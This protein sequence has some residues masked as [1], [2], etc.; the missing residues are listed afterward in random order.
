MTITAEWAA[1]IVSAGTLGVAW[2]Q[3]GKINKQIKLGVEN[4]RQEILRIVLEIENQINS[5]KLELDRAT[6][7]IME[8]EE[9]GNEI[10]DSQIYHLKSAQ[11]SFLNSVDRLCFC[12]LKGY[13][14]DKDWKSE[15][16][17]LA[18]NTIKDKNFSVY[19]GADSAYRN[20]IKL[21]EKRQNE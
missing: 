17:Y 20:I 19:F 8:S 15:Y 2:W 3:L 5:R 14:P 13:I 16:K 4:Q 1:C 12:I 11:E 10:L 7:S 21:N 6:K 9:V 18:Y